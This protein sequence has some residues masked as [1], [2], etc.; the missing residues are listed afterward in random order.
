MDVVTL[1]A[2][3]VL[4]GWLATLILHAEVDHVSVLNFTIAIIGA[5]LAGGLLAPALGIPPTGEYGLSLLGTVIS[6][7]GATALLALANLLRYGRLVCGRRRSARRAAP[8]QPPSPA[9]TRPPG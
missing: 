8:M 4:V 2:V 3:A 1:L 7:A 9:T 6:W 5:A